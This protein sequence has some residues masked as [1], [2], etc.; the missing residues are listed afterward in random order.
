MRS[1]SARVRS[2]PIFPDV[3]ALPVAVLL[4]LL[5][6]RPDRVVA[7]VETEQA[8]HDVERAAIV[9]GRAGEID[10]PRDQVVA[11]LVRGRVEPQQGVPEHRRRVVEEG[12]GEHEADAAGI[13]LRVPGLEARATLRGQALRVEGQLGREPVMA[14]DEAALRGLAVR[15]A[16]RRREK[17]SECR[18]E[19]RLRVAVAVRCE[20]ESGRI[21]VAA[22][23]RPEPARVIVQQAPPLRRVGE[24][25]LAGARDQLGAI[26][27]IGRGARRERSEA[28]EGGE[29]GDAR[30]QRAKPR[31]PRPRERAGTCDGDQLLA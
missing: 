19:L 18:L 30:A 4:H 21:G 15:V 13:E 20:K 23:A 28:A 16:R 14:C 3:A 12:F 24:V 5:V 29:S 1:I 7:R 6:I 11:P 22:R 17:T 10:R 31:R 26:A 27:V 25:Q 2:E 9:A 8:L